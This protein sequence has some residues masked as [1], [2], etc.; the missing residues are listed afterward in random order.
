MTGK[1]LDDFYEILFRP[2]QGMNKISRE[3]T[4]WHG[5]LVYIGVSVIVSLSSG[6]YHPDSLAGDLGGLPF[7]VEVTENMLRVLPF[8]N[9]LLN[10]T[11]IPVVFLIWTSI[12]HLTAD[13]LGGQNRS[14]RLGAVIGYGQLPYVFM[15]PVSLLSQ[16]L[17]FDLIGIASLVLFLWSLVLKIVGLR[18]TYGFS[19]SKA[20]LSYFLPVGVLLVSLIIFVIFLSLFFAPFIAEFIPN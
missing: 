11:F 4:I 2:T 19:T 3:K 10:V 13:I 18:E 14:Y 16:Y 8:F 6:S 15:A 5:L 9:V 1:F 7:P 17:P 20:I 12:L